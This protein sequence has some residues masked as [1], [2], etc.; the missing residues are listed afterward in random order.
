MSG[1]LI[2]LDSDGIVNRV[3]EP[4]LAAQVSLGRLH[5]DVPEQKL[6]LLQLPAGFM[7]QTRARPASRAEQRPQIRIW[8]KPL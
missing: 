3:P 8:R 2:R 1:S 5:A 4:L 7:T 6:D